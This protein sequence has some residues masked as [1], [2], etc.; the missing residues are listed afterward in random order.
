VLAFGI[1]S[2][3]VT[4]ALP[5]VLVVLL[6]RSRSAR[7]GGGPA[8]GRSVRR[9]FQYLLLY[10]L[11]IVAVVG[12]SDL[13]ARAVDGPDVSADDSDLARVLA[14]A[15][16]GVPMVAA[17]AAW[18]RRELRRDP[19]ERRSLGWAVYL[20]GATLTSLVVGIVTLHEGLSEAMAGRL[21]WSALIR[22][23]VWGAVWA[24]HWALGERML[25]KPAWAPHLAIGA[26]I[27]LGVTVAGLI[28]CGGAVITTA[29][30]DPAH[31]LGDRELAQAG[32]LV[33]VGAL[34]WFGYWWRRF[35][36]VAPRGLWLG[37]VLPVGVGG[38]FVVAVVA[39]AIVLDTLLVWIVGDPRTT[40]AASYFAGT[41]TAG[42]AVVVG[43]ASW[44]YHRRAFAR[45]APAGRTEITRL[46][47]YLLA[48]IALTATAVGVVIGVRALADMIAATGRGSIANTV[49][50]AGTLLVVGGPLW[51]VFWRR[52]Q[53]ARRADPQAEAGSVTR[54][55]YLFVLFGVGGL[56][57]VIAVLVAGFIGIDAALK[58]DLGSSTMTDLGVPAGLLIAAAAVSGYHWLVYRRDRI[59]AP[60]QEVRVGPRD[61]LLLG[62]VD[63]D[64]VRAARA[65][66]ARVEV[67]ARPGGAWDGPAV[68]A[69]LEEHPGEAVAV[70]L[71][72]T[73]AELLSVQAVLRY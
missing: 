2:S 23:G 46:H 61:V 17:V 27:G 43:V 50:T 67:W 18:T 8:D 44:W 70:V 60:R 69:M 36:V 53:R 33:V 34:V 16:F 58:G 20:T 63:D 19:A 10:G 3:L 32:A 37:Y 1:L 54:R 21:D 55:V 66:G 39:A 64:L 41:P 22:A 5:V 56:V 45:S 15:L 12:V 42:S 31:R 4:F 24:G 59:A 72:A 30:G 62:P 9:F 68:L 38:S 48:G 35:R 29:L 51:S 52:A 25:S 49:I 7:T 57:A 11:M 65:T 40:V 26:L 13:L 14:F 6:V 47:E 73:G 71:G 28:W